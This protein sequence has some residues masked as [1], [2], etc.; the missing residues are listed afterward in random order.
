MERNAIYLITGPMASGKSTIAELVASSLPKAVHLR[1]DI[2][3]R[4]ITSGR[5]EMSANP[6]EEAIRQLYMRY[7]MTA[8]A[9]AAYYDNGFSVVMQDNYYGETLPYVCGLLGG[10]PLCVTVLCPDVDVIRQREAH[11]DKKGYTGFSPDTLYGEFMLKTPRIGF[12]LDN[13]RQTP[14]ESAACILERFAQ[15]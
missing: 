5:E 2:F 11:R 12:W 14:E 9:A 6:T 4:M 15:P 1:G 8:D 13:S 10:R 3:R 7:R